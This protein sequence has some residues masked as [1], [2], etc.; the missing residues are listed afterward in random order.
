MKKNVL[1]LGGDGQDGIILSRI[2]LNNGYKVTSVTRGKESRLQTLALVN[3]ELLDSNFYKISCDIS[4][5]KNFE[6]LLFLESPS[7]IINCSGVSAGAAMRKSIDVHMEQVFFPVET[8]CNWINRNNR[9]CRFV[10]LSSREV[11]GL[12]ATLPINEQTPRNPRNNYGIAKN[13]TDELI[14]K[15]RQKYGTFLCSAILSNHVSFLSRNE[16]LLKKIAVYCSNKKKL[17]NFGEKLKIGSLKTERSWLSAYDTCLCIFKMCVSNHA[18]DYVIGSSKPTS[19]EELLNVSF[20]YV[21]LEWRQNVEVDT[22]LDHTGED[23]SFVCDSS[24]ARNELDWLPEENMKIIIKE[25][26]DDCGR[27]LT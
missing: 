8:I 22:T 20:G 1:I 23:G 24:N 17:N 11:F 16:N 18:K 14:L 6:R 9:K 10:Q 7:L 13:L 19:I 26:I 27:Y 15:N 12:P 25:L 21:G 4:D 3:R 2:F 5:L